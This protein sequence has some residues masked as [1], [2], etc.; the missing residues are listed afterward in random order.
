MGQILSFN[1]LPTAARSA[2]IAD[3][4]LNLP[5]GNFSRISDA[6]S[7]HQE[8]HLLAQSGPPTIDVIIDIITSCT[9]LIGI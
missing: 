1:R 5:I 8:E 3:P 2:L 9:V 7:K 4:C 6:G